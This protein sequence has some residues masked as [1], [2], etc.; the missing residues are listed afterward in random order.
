M[1][2]VR[3]WARK[4]SEIQP[5]VDVEAPPTVPMVMKAAYK[6]RARA[7]SYI[8]QHYHSTG[9]AG[10]AFSWRAAMLDPNQP[11]TLCTERREYRSTTAADIQVS[12]DDKRS[13]GGP[14][15]GPFQTCIPGEAW[16]ALPKYDMETKRRSFAFSELMHVEWENHVDH[17]LANN[18]Q[19]PVAFV[20]AKAG[21]RSCSPC[22]RDMLALARPTGKTFIMVDLADDDHRGTFHFVTGDKYLPVPKEQLDKHQLVA[23]KN[24]VLDAQNGLYTSSEE[25]YNA[26]LGSGVPIDEQAQHM[27]LG[28]SALMP[29]RSAETLKGAELLKVLHAEH[30]ARLTAE[31]GASILRDSNRSQKEVRAVLECR[32]LAKQMLVAAWKPNLRGS[33]LQQL[34]A[35]ADAAVQ[36]WLPE[37]DRE[38][39]PLK[40]ASTAAIKLS[41]RT[42]HFKDISKPQPCLKEI[43]DIDAMSVAD[44]STAVP[45][46]ESEA[47]LSEKNGF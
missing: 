16:V 17:I 27:Y 5:P 6:D 32:S 10:G 34:D 36:P 11:L 25:I 46:D 14:R 8:V 47:D 21:F 3:R 31:Y 28:D 38:Y 35:Y 41:G 37:N 26:V 9:C 7:P 12:K 33:A 15:V 24:I 1:A 18:G 30:F 45:D 4:S 44:A 22:C 2:A 43:L 13:G 20:V 39:T 29:A 42:K 23:M 40:L 19:L